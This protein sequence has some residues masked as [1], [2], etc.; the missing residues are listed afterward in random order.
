[1]KEISNEQLKNIAQ[2]IQ[3]RELDAARAQLF[4]YLDQNPISEQGWLLLCATTDNHSEIRNYLENV[5]KINPD[6]RVA[7]KKLMALK[8]KL[9][10]KNNR[11]G[12]EKKYSYHNNNGKK[13]TNSK[14]I[15]NKKTN[16]ALV[17]F[18]RGFILIIVLLLISAAFLYSHFNKNHHTEIALA[19]QYQP[20]PTQLIHKAT[21]AATSQQQIITTPNGSN[22]VD[23]NVQSTP[24]IH[25]T[26][27]PSKT[28]T[29]INPTSEP[30][31]IELPTPSTSTN[32][33]LLRI[34]EQVAKA[35]G[36]EATIDVPVYI[37]SK[38]KVKQI[39]FEDLENRNYEKLLTNEAATLVQ[40]GLI[41]KNLNYI[42]YTNKTLLN[43]IAGLYTP[44][45]QTIFLL[46][47]HLD[48][49]DQYYYAHEFEHAL[50][51][52]N[53]EFNQ[54]GIYPLCEGN[55][56]QCLARYA[57]IEGDA[58]QTEHI[59]LK[60]YANASVK[61]A[62]KHPKSSEQEN[63]FLEMELFDID[64]SLFVYNLGLNFVEQLYYP[65]DWEPVNEA[66]NKPPLSTEQILHLKK[67]AEYE[68]PKEIPYVDLHETLSD[69]WE[70]LENNVLGEWMT[71]VFLIDGVEKDYRQSHPDSRKAAKGWG[72]DNYQVYRNK[73]TGE[74]LLYV[75][76]T[77]DSQQDS[78]EFY[79]LM[80]K[81]LSDRYQVPMVN[82]QNGL[83]WNSNHQ[84][85]C[86]YQNG[87]DTL[88]ITA[89]DIQL[90][91]HLTNHIAGFTD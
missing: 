4:L 84:S 49:I 20:T 61:N 79:S 18:I 14:I 82:N 41:K 28:L 89:P 30:I 57:L 63:P 64:T 10:Q 67:F 25:Q 88:W 77:W 60:K 21:K 58:Q 74:T 26:P 34:Q 55:K 70:I 27:I 44:Q 17:F 15:R 23:N 56:D 43:G 76:W 36:L 24:E 53:F 32:S 73:E 78:D 46:T 80:Q 50:A 62:L 2:L 29:T 54:W 37:A 68:K 31:A 45:R 83:C 9:S 66:F 48:E 51:D 42:H 85:S 8:Q 75:Y 59:W 52:Q 5:I 11:R 6:N 3:A 69:D 87:L 16:N 81:Y 35:R 1:M 22:G 7:K 38:N 90:I 40:L 39:I 33:I 12:Q 13:Q 91:N 65:N 19:K 47:S 72:G 86:L 71:Y